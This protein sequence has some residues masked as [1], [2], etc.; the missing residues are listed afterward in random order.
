MHGS[1]CYIPKSVLM[2]EHM[3]NNMSQINTV[4][5]RPKN[6]GSLAVFDNWHS[7]VSI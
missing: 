5:I 2:C 1:T 3:K 4:Y 7:V 6:V